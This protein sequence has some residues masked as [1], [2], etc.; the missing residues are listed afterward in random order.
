MERF[1]ESTACRLVLVFNGV[2]FMIS[3][4]FRIYT[5]SSCV[6]FFIFSFDHQKTI[7]SFFSGET[8]SLQLPSLLFI[9]FIIFIIP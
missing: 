7:T 5:I 1:F 8:I 6:I 3:T 9:I 4:S 2:V